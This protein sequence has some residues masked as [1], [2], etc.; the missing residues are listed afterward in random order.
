MKHLIIGLCFMAQSYGECRDDS[1]SIKEL[2][3]KIQELNAKIEKIS[4]I[5]IIANYGKIPEP[6]PS[7]GFHITYGNRWRN[8]IDREIRYLLGQNPYPY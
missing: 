4:E 7:D 3:T 5:P 1:Q 6:P 8:Q 2:N